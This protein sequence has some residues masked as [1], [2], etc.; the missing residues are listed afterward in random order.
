MVADPESQSSYRSQL[1]ELEPTIRY[2]G[3]QMGKKASRPVKG[4][5][6]GV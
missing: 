5:L 4:L 6:P 1:E 2:C 3:Y